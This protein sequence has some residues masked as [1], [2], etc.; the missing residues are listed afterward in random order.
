M[1]ILFIKWLDGICFNFYNF[2]FNVI[3][4]LVVVEKLWM[5]IK[6]FLLVQFYSV[7]FVSNDICK[8]SCKFGDVLKG[9]M[10]LY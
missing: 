3:G 2:I 5:V 4:D 6:N 10:F 8:V 1:F 9:F 7:L